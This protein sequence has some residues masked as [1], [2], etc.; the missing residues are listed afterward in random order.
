MS[1]RPTTVFR[2]RDARPDDLETVVAFNAALASES[3][4]K[5]LD[6]EILTRGVRTALGEPDRLRYWV[7]EAVETGQVIGQAAVSREWSDWRNGWIWW[8]QSV[9]VQP[10]SRTQGVFRSLY[11]HIRDTARNAGDVVGL[12]LYVDD[13]NRRA[14]R[15]YAAMGM[16]PGGYHVLEA[17]FP[18]GHGRRETGLLVSG[19]G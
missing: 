8:L 5:Q 19:E 7:A 18:E 15:T 17:M 2:V 3:E 4:S 10:E 9:Y 12:R 16:A 1:D 6:R 14:Q 11:A 13:A